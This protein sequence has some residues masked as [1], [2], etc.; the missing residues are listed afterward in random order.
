MAPL[1]AAALVMLLAW[2][3][4]W[5]VQRELRRLTDPAYLRAHGVVIVRPRAV[6]LDAA[7][8]G[9]YRGEPIAAGLT[10]KGMRYRF[11]RVIPRRERERI[12]PGELYLEPGL[13][14]VS[15]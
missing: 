10:F 7:V 3:L 2:P 15:D 5:A 8:V 14:Y 9:T 12:G 11:D 1:E 6:T 4:H 13:I